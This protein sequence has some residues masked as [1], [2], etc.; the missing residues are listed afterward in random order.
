M[1]TSLAR[2]PD[3]GPPDLLFLLSHGQG[4]S[5]DAMQP[6]AVALAG[7]YPQ[8]AVLCLQAPDPAD[9]VSGK[10]EATG[11][12]Q[13]FSRLGL[14]EDNRAERINAAVP[15]FI[16]TIRGLQQHFDMPWQRTALAGFSQGAI[17]AMEAVQQEPEL[18]GRV[19]AFSGRY[20][21]LP[22]HAPVDTSVHLFHGMLDRVIPA[23]PIIDAAK[24][25]VL[26]GADVTADIL[27]QVGHELHPLMIDKALGQLRTFLPRRLWREAVSEAP[28]MSR[29]ASSRELQ[30]R[31]DEASDER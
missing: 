14:T 31:G 21:I 26:L 2:L 22:E 17:L 6:L 12:Y 9:D 30:G 15:P 4:Q 16:A 25:L 27:P 28:L 13:Y 5:P 8:A 11:G 19:L 10:G 3:Q 24:Q 1:V 7:E 29:Q 18:A 20:G 23:A